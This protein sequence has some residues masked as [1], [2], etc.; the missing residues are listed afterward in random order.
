MLPFSSGKRRQLACAPGNKEHRLSSLFAQR[1]FTP[2]TMPEGL[3][4]QRVKN[5]LGAQAT[6]PC[7]KL[8][9]SVAGT[10][11]SREQGTQT[12]ESVR[13]AEF[14]SADDAGRVAKTAG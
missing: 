6:G 1:S 5:P 13:P 8:P 12:F 4:R 2:L 9:Q 3:P 11:R 10:L 7:S 14:Y